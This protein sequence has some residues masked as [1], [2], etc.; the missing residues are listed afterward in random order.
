MSPTSNETY[1]RRYLDDPITVGVQS[2]E[3]AQENLNLHAGLNAEQAAF[4]QQLNANLA[5]LRIVK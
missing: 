5:P 4:N 2:T 1:Y 3:T